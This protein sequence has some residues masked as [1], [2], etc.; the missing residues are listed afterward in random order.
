MEASDK[1]HVLIALHLQK[2]TL[3]PIIFNQF[4]N[5]YHFMYFPE[6]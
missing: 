1:L 3:I 4:K 6:H 2:E 5:C